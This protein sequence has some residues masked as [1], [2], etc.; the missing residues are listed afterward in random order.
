MYQQQHQQLNI[1]Q[2]LLMQ[3]YQLRQMYYQQMQQ[4]EGLDS[5]G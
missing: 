3:Q 1:E 2:Q 5:S 4:M